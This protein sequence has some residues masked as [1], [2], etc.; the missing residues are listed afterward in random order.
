MALSREQLK[1][2]F[3]QLQSQIDAIEAEST[4]KRIFRDQKVN[5]YDAYIRTLD[6]EIKEIEKDLVEL[7]NQQG[8]ASRAIGGQVG[9]RPD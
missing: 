8:M 7:K 6:T 3:W 2:E 5:E 4:P 1:K 9:A